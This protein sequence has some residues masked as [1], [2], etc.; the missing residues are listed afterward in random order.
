MGKAGSVKVSRANG[1]K[2]NGRED[3]KRAVITKVMTKRS[4]SVESSSES[5][6]GA[7]I[8]KLTV[9]EKNRV[10]KEKQRRTSRIAGPAAL[11]TANPVFTVGDPFWNSAW[12]LLSWAW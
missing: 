6:T 11:G 7:L 12:Q 1:D 3:D 8:R 2:A 5:L 4:P 9:A 10:L